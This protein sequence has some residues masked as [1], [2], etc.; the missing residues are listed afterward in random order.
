MTK[1]TNIKFPLISNNLPLDLVNTEVVSYGK[2]HNL[3]KS[4]ED[5]LEWLRLMSKVTPFFNQLT[6]KKA[7]D[8]L[9]TVMVEKIL[10]LRSTLRENF[11][12][13]ADGEEPGESFITFLEKKIELAPFTYKIL[14]TKL[15][16]IPIGNIDDAIISLIAYDGLSLIYT[17]KINL[18]KRCANEEC[19]LLFIDNTGR[20]K[21]CSMK[22]CGNREK[23]SRHLKKT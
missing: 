14:D 4:K 13:I 16:R 17:K 6:L 21:W 15:A 19:V 5:L 8:E 10:E 2:R 7:Q 23:V 3:L 11:E 12:K 20:R 9:T 18:I 22:I 1:K